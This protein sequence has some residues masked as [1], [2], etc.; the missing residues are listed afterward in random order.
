MFIR[1]LPNYKQLNTLILRLAWSCT[2][3]D[4]RRIVLAKTLA[5]V[6]NRNIN[7]EDVV[8]EDPEMKSKGEGFFD[9]I[10]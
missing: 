6:L 2:C 9:Y 3:W 8:Y 10:N 5:D 4:S 7:G 1:H